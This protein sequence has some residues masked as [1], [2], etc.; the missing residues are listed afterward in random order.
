MEDYPKVYLYKRIVQAKLY[1]DGNYDREI[2]LNTILNE[3][4]FSK[5]HFIR[6]FR[7]IYG[8][9]PHQYLIRVRI[10]KAK[11]LLRLNTSVSETCVDVGFQ[12]I[13]SFTTLFK[14]IT[15]V[16]PSTYL[17]QHQEHIRA[18]AKKPLFFIPGCF[19]EKKGWK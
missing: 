10:D 2:N 12:S 7:K 5:F 14:R 11:H 18:I 6:L 1:M 17:N 15:G 3:A 8:L 19:A 16:S 9:T 13:S 4:C